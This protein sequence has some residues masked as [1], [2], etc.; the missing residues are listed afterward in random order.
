MLPVRSVVLY[1][2]GAS[3]CGGVLTLL[4]LP[5]CSLLRRM[6]VPSKLICLLWIAVGLRFF[7]PGGIPVSV[8]QAVH[9]APLPSALEQT[10]V[11]L[12]ALPAQAL[13][14]AGSGSSTV[15]VKVFGIWH[16]LALIWC[17]G[18]LFLLLRAAVGYI[19]LHRTVALACKTP[20]DCYSCN[21][22]AVPFTLGIL[23]PRIYMPQ[24]LCGAP[25]RAILL[26]ETTHI[27]RGDTITKPLYYLA[28]CLHWWNPLAWLAFR[29]FEQ[30]MEL[31]CDEAAIGTAPA[32]DRAD[33]CESI[34][35]FAT[36]KQIP[37]S[38]AFGQGKVAQ[39]VAHVLKYQ[40]PA[41]LLLVLGCA[42]VALGCTACALR[43]QSQPAIPLSAESPASV[44]TAA[45]PET[46]PTPQPQVSAA[47]EQDAAAPANALVFGWPMADF[48]YIQ[49]FKDDTHRGMDYA[50]DSGTPV[51]A[52]YGGT[53][54]V[55]QEHPSYG[56]HV[57]IDHG[58]LPDGH[59]YRTLYAHMDT[60]LVAAG[61]TVTQGQQ[62]GT[63]GDTGDASSPALH[64]ELYID[65]QLADPRTMIPYDH[66]AL[67]D[68]NLSASLD[69]IMPVTDH[70]SVSAPFDVSNSAGK[71][72]LGTDFAASSG[73]P[74]L[75][76]QDGVVTQSGWDD[77]EGY[78]V[79]IYHGVNGSANYAT[80]YA[81]LQSAPDVQPGQQVAQGDVIG[82]V[83]S[84]GYSTGSH[85]HFEVLMNGTPI[86]PFAVLS[87]AGLEQ[88]S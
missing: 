23:R 49:R 70:T 27:R 21:A 35:H 87:P 25:R 72:H 53:V 82:H 58:T 17:T 77:A 15:P 55:A 6:H 12:A 26:H 20:D 36:A 22:V 19:R 10:L 3:L 48:H 56:N 54:T 30:Y 31:A 59:S 32:A 63:A 74:V 73:T 42:V 88:Q 50:A 4:C 68:L 62:L 14:S 65:G 47:P 76:V 84:T 16:L 78:F 37:G 5:L 8:P 45:E 81:N 33:Y 2:A 60:L 18:I 86:D 9:T 64:I 28:A 29:Q 79:N 52:V 1:A 11:P 34:L 44:Q 75:A 38:L 67:P 13:P 69:F 40:K 57:I 39:R 80:R 24:D 46:T 61:D 51:L 7:V 83:G 85:L 43:P 71:P 41:P 66:T